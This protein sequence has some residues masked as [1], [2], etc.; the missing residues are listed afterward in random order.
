MKKF[1][2]ILTV[3]ILLTSCSAPKIKYSDQDELSN[4]KI[5]K[6]QVNQFKNIAIVA[7]K[8]LTGKNANANNAISIAETEFSNAGFNILERKDFNL[9]VDEHLFANNVSLYKLKSNF[10]PATEIVKLTITKNKK[11]DYI[12]F[13]LLYNSYTAIQ[14]V[15]VDIK[16]INTTNGLIKSVTGEGQSKTSAS[17]FLFFGTYQSQSDE[18]FQ[19]T[20][21]LAIRNAISKL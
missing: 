11:W 2:C 13:Y 19:E 10:P 20:L 18:L 4:F 16:L 3:L 12:N 1:F 14:E 21:R 5:K 17:T 9:I 7:F 15:R 6:E 8:D